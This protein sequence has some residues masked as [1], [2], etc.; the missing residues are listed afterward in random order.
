MAIGVNIMMSNSFQSIQSEFT[1]PYGHTTPGEVH[2]KLDISSQQNRTA[3]TPAEVQ[4]QSLAQREEEE[5]ALPSISD[6]HYQQSSLSKRIGYEHNDNVI[7]MDKQENIS[8][9]RNTD[10][11]MSSVLVDNEDNLNIENNDPTEHEHEYQQ[12]RDRMQDTRDGFIP[13]DTEHE[14]D[15]ITYDI[16]QD[17]DLENVSSNH[18]QHTDSDCK[19]DFGDSIMPHDTEHVQDVYDNTQDSRDCIIPNDT[20]HE[21]DLITY[22]IMQDLDLENVS[23]NHHQHIDSGYMHDSGDSIMPH[24]TEHVQDVY[25]NMQDSR[26]GIIPND[27][28]HEQ[29]LITYDIMQDLDLENVSSN[30]HQ[31]IDSDCKHDFGDSIMPHDTEHVQDVYDNTQDS[32]DCIIP[33]DTEHEQ[34]LITYDIMQ[35]LDLE[36]VSSNHHQHI[37]SDCKHD[38]GDSIMPHDTEHVQDVYDNT[39]DSRDCII[40]NDTEHEQD[41][42]MDDS[43]Q[44]LD[45]E[46]V[47]SNHHQ[48][49]DS[50]YMPK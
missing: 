26:D 28:E 47:S 40:P 15:L 36:N 10:N 7:V 34:D 50:G 6:Q 49:I 38:F 20:E 30:H 29:D 1:F 19:H 46:S 27:T 41:L 35:D 22:D 32:R 5:D 48:H 25:D 24:D 23:S 39:Q 12:L 42:F 14:Q 33:N 43:M 9:E 8:I 2:L 37:D 44:D 18:H 13:N 4:N 21:Q 17:L 3:T 16:M 45:L 31:H 11:L